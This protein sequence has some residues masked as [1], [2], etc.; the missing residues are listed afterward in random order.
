V[1]RA[2]EI[3]WLEW[4]AIAAGGACAVLVLIGQGRL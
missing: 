2:R 3:S 4:F 1:K